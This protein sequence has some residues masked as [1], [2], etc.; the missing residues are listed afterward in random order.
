M[1]KWEDLTVEAYL[2]E[3]DQLRGELAG[4]RGEREMSKALALEADFL[5]DLPA[6]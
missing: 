5:R 6:A 4:P 3:R 2:A 1:F